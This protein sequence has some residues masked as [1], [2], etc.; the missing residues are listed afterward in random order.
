MKNVNK[1][2]MKEKNSCGFEKVHEFK[3]L[4]SW[5]LQIKKCTD[6]KMFMNFSNIIELE[7]MFTNSNN[8]HGFG[9]CSWILKHGLDFENSSQNFQNVHEFKF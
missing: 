2:I 5:W 6:L 4:R 1:K 8:V 3:N 9:Y 7:K